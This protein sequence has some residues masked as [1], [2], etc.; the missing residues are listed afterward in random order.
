MNN[1]REEGVNSFGGNW[2]DI[3]CFD[4]EMRNGIHLDNP[5]FVNLYKETTELITSKIEFSSF[6]DLGGGVGA[7]CQ[8]MKKAGKQ[9]TYYDLN[10]HHF[11]YAHE[12]NVADS[13]HLGDF[14]TMVIKGDLVSCIEVAEHITDEKLI[15]FFSRL[16]CNYLHFSSTPFYTK[17][18]EDWGHINIKP[19]AHWIE[20]FSKFG[21]TLHK[22]IEKPT[23]WS[24]LLKK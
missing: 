7:Y 10:P 16:E 17:F 23:K 18:D 19:K 6:T 2:S 21:Y 9:V 15:P 11:E 5:S 24:L 3:Q 4:W 8:Q 22:E 13:Y 20:F 12:R 1:Q 14:T